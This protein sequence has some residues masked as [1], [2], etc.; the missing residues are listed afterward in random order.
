VLSEGAGEQRDKRLRAALLGLLDARLAGLVDDIA[1]VKLALLREAVSAEGKA[2]AMAKS[3]W[4]RKEAK[5]GRR[6]KKPFRRIT[7]KYV[8][9]IRAIFGL[10]P[11][12]RSAARRSEIA[13]VTAGGTDAH[14]EKRRRG[15]ADAGVTARPES[16]PAPKAAGEAVS[17]ERGG[18]VTSGPGM[19]EDAIS[20]LGGG[21]AG[22]VVGRGDAVDWNGY[23]PDNM[24]DRDP[25]KAY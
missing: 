14:V 5:A 13:A 19:F 6:G 11:E 24:E 18:A 4:E 7:L 10:P 20:V 8:N 15:P 2:V 16:V 22:A 12:K 1:E 9:H 25:Y 17:R 3:R 21:K 23:F